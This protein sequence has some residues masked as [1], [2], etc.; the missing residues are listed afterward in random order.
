MTDDEPLC[1]T[2]ERAPECKYDAAWE[3]AAYEPAPW[4]DDETVGRLTK[5]G[6]I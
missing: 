2:C 6:M 3:C 4:A 5:E 1:A